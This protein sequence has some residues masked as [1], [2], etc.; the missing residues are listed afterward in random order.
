MR[1]TLGVTWNVIT[2][3][4]DALWRAE[5]GIALPG[6]GDAAGLA[7]RSRGGHEPPTAAT[8]NEFW[9][10]RREADLT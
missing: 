6:G 8:A 5:A 3:L 1:A 7:R 2:V 10:D 4:G 9:S